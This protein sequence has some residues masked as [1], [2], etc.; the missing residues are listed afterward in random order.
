M[1]GGGG[2]R[3]FI[4]FSYMRIVYI[5]RKEKKCVYTRTTL[6]IS[7]CLCAIPSGGSPPSLTLVRCPP[8]R[9]FKKDI[10]M[11]EE[12]EKR[13]LKSRVETWFDVK[14]RGSTIKTEIRAGFVNF[15]ANFYLIVVVRRFCVSDR[16][17]KYTQV[18]SFII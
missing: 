16:K 9:T 13:S 6:I 4:V 2:G 5:Y 14:N 8:F 7:S 15:L 18:A 17:K 3:F 10:M 12:V 11:E 1:V